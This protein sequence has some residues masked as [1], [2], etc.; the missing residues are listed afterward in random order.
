[1]PFTTDSIAGRLCVGTLDSIVERTGLQ[2]AVEL[3]LLS[4]MS[5]DPVGVMRTWTGGKGV[6]K[7]VYCGLAVDAIGLDSH[8]VFAFT[9]GDSLVPHFTLDSVFGQGTYAFHLDLIP[10][11]DMGANL[12]YVNE[13]YQP[14]LEVYEE[15]EAREG[16]SKAA[17]GPR[18]RAVMSPW[19]LT[20]R[21]T[22]QAFLAMS[23]PVNAYRDHWFGLLDAGLPADLA[24]EPDLAGRD[25]RNRNALFSREV[26]PV[27][28]TITRLIGEQAEQ[29]RLQLV[30]ND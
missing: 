25:S 13:V 20:N 27:W 19:M 15:V 12:Q 8:M 23:G 9:D 30:S 21:A 2:P 16:F 7:A 10:R 6:A 1:M 26:D 11:A 28:D 4:A 5:P 18:Q 3:P 29:I 22:E 14:L 17:I 24:I